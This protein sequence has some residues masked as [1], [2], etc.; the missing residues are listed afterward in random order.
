L[1]PI[2]KT[3]PIAVFHDQEQK[4]LVDEVVEESH[5]R[6]MVQLIQRAHFVDKIG[7]T[8]GVAVSQKLDG[9]LSPHQFVF[10]QVHFAESAASK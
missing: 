8:I 9:D 2:A 6:R 3:P 5:D 10:R 1:H 7:L 4:L